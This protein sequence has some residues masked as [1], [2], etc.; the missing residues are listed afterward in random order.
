MIASGVLYLCI[1][2]QHCLNAQH[3]D[4]VT[5]VTG[6]S[7][8]QNYSLLPTLY[9]P[10]LSSYALCRRSKSLMPKY[11]SGLN[12]KCKIRVHLVLHGCDLKD[13]LIIFQVPV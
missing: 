5:T 3:Y 1:Q 4:H 10:T 7:S 2:A 8:R 11:N 6:Q 12:G 13:R 9:A